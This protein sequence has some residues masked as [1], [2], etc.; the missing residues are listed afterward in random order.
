MI[1]QIFIRQPTQ[2]KASINT[3]DIGMSFAIFCDLPQPKVSW[4]CKNPEPSAL[5]PLHNL[6]H[7]NCLNI[8][9]DNII[10]SLGLRPAKN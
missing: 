5:Q 4:L 3:E 10:P 6:V 1:L 9:C 7:V 8:M 2:G